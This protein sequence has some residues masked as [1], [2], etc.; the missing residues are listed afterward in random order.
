MAI[1]LEGFCPAEA[2]FSPWGSIL[3]FLW[4]MAY[5]TIDHIS[6]VALTIRP[7]N[8]RMARLPGIIAIVR[9]QTLDLVMG[10]SERRKTHIR[11]GNHK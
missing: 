10:V 7:V 4:R 2:R 11:C 9:F 6:G 1:Y 3:S 5:R 8:L